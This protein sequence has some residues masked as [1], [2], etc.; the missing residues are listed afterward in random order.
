MKKEKEYRP[1]TTRQLII[2]IVTVAFLLI[3]A[4]ALIVGD[5]IARRYATVISNFLGVGEQIEGDKTKVDEAAKTSDELVR[6][7]A[8]EGIVL[9]KNEDEDGIPVLPLAKDNATVNLFGF[10]ATDAGILLSGDGSGRSNPHE[11]LI[12]TLTEAFTDCGVMYN[13]EIIKIYKGYRTTQDADWGLSASWANRYST[14][15]KEPVTDRYFTDDVMERAKA[16]SDTAVIVLSR[17]SGEFLGSNTQSQQKKYNLPT[18]TSRE[19]G[20]ISTEEQSLIKLC[21]ETFNNVVIVFNC[22]SMMDMTFL[23]TG[24]APDGE[25]IG[26]PDAA[27]VAGYLGQ[28]GASAIPRIIYGDVNPSAKLADTVVYNPRENELTRYNFTE[29]EADCVYTEGVY[30]GYKFYET[31]AAERYYDERTLDG[32][33]KTDYDAVVQYPFGYGLSYTDFSWSVKET[34]LTDGSVLEKDDTVTITVTVTNTGDVAGKDVVQLYYAPPY[35]DGEIEKPAISLVDFAKTPTLEPEMSADVTLSFSAYDLASYD[36][37][38]MNKNGYAAWELDESAAHT[39]KFMSDAHTPKADM[40]R[41]ANAPGGE[42]TYTVTKDI[43]WTTD[44]VSGNE[45]VNRFTGD[46]AYLGVPL[47]G[48]TLGQGWTY[49]TRAAWADSVCA[50]EYPNLSVNVDDKAVAYSGYDSVFTEMPPFGVDAGAEYKLVLRA[51]G[52]VAQNGDFTNAGVELKYN[53]DL[54]F[55]LADPEHYNDP[56][57]AKWKTFLDQLTKEEIR[58][59]VE[60]AGYGSKEAYG[61]GKNIWTDQD[62]PSGFNTSNF[63]PNNDS[64]LTAFPTENMVGQTWSKDLLFQMGQVIGV[65]AE[66]FNMSGIY[67]PGVNLHKNSFGARN[68]EY[69][70]E[71][72]VLSGIYAAQFSLGA[73]SNGAMVYVKHLVCYDYQTIGRVWLN[74]QTFRETYLRPFEIAIKE[75]GATGLMSSFNKVGPEWT[76]GNHAMINDVIRGEWGFNGVVITDYQD[77]STER[78]AMPHSLRAR[79]GLQLNPNRG[80]AGRYGRIDTD[81]PVEMNL[82]RLTVKD[83]VYAKCNVYY[84]AKNN[85]IQNEFTIEISGPRAVTYGFAWWIMLLVF[86]NVIVF[87]LLIWR[88]IALALP[89][90]RDVRMRK[91]ATAGGPDDDPFGGPR[92]RDATEVKTD[93]SVFPAQSETDTDGEHASDGKEENNKSEFTVAVAESA[94]TAEESV[95]AYAAL[96]EVS[97][98]S[99]V[100]AEIDAIRGRIDGMDKKLEELAAAVAAISANQAAKKSASGGKSS[101]AKRRPTSQTAELRSGMEQMDKKLTAMNEMLAALTEM[102]AGGDDRTDDSSE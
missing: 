32:T 65:D 28:S 51:D 55:Y 88:G 43:V 46:T 44:P 94:A 53:D 101:S 36:C 42:L 71:D 1:T 41:D 95:A 62:G 73:K 67:A 75:G 57:D 80:T 12:V 50:S 76:G 29:N 85:T 15:L 54:M 81:S 23:E 61:I 27:L 82:A 18:D 86:I 37:Y 6:K 58:L 9:V 99:E 40:D 84:A 26:R 92:K 59:I 70:S 93:L 66:N 2:R 97:V 34:N 68:Y 77:G 33:D 20:Q 83:I 64:K 52:T 60:D 38:D 72:S 35:V 48:S 16:F 98:S 21:N 39:L 19:Y 56:D 96:P 25:E 74:E 10:G 24:R 79:A 5:V 49:L 90:V 31:A 63:N 13:Q 14:T 69:F 45:V 22:G 78:M 89:L 100:R 102:R 17:Y 8:D 47:D 87:G 4:A 7:I 30:V 11:D 91:K 3:V